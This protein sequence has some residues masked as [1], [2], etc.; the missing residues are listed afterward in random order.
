MDI[1]E[2]LQKK[3]TLFK[4]R[5]HFVKYRWEMFHP[6]SWLAIYTGYD[7][8]PDSYD[9]GVDSF[10]TGYIEESLAAMKAAL[11]KAVDETPLLQEFL[12]TLYAV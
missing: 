9:P 11:Q 6:S 8:L 7:I 12:D 4:A 2:T 3:I 5:G 10:E 1:P